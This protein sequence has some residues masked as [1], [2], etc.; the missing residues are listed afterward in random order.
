M[1][2]SLPRRVGPKNGTFAFTPEGEKQIHDAVTEGHMSKIEVAAA[3]GASLPTIDAILKRVA[4]RL[5]K[6]AAICNA[7]PGDEHRD[8]SGVA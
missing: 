4:A 1:Q 8:D 7:N 6:Q 5:A 3:V 2:V